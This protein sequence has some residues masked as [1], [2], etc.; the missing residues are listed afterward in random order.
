MASKPSSVTASQQAVKTNLAK[1]E[2]LEV[3]NNAGLD[4]VFRGTIK[5]DPKA[6]VLLESKPDGLY[7]TDLFKGS[8]P[9]GEG[10]HLLSEVIRGSGLK[11]NGKMI[12]EGVINQPT[13][14]MFKVGA[15]ASASVLGKAGATALNNLGLTAKRVYFDIVKGKKVVIFEL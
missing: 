14:E 1:I 5:G 11:V 6:F 8:L 10:G 2:G 13:L 9:K 4:N 12:M 3:V 15:D 7:V